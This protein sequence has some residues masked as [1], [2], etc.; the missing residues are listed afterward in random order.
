MLKARLLMSLQAIALCTGAVF[1][2]AT[3]QVEEVYDFSRRAIEQSYS[4]VREATQGLAAHT[5]Y[6]PQH[7]DLFEPASIPVVVWANGACRDSNYGFLF[8]STMVSSHGFIVVA[9]GA[10]DAPAITGG[11]V[12]PQNQIDAMDWLAS[13][14]GQEQLQGRADLEKIAVAGQSCGGLEALIAGADPRTKTILAFNT[15]FFEDCALDVC[16]DELENLHTP[17][18]F[19]NGG[20]SDIAYEN[21]IANYNLTQT[22]A[23]LA[24]HKYVGHSGLLYGIREGQGDTTVLTQAERTYVNWLDFM[25]NGNQQAWAYF[26]GANCDLCNHDDWNITSKNWD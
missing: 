8:I 10:F 13:E 21:S 20:P 26:F 14:E 24:E 1:Q 25:L 4:T 7:L 3:A 22:P 15:G 9:N 19:V 5:L 11:A 12:V 2:I 18:L 16:R 23:Y 6:R 17:V